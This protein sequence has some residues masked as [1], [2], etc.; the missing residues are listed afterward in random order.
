M[1]NNQVKVVKYYILLPSTEV[2]T[3]QFIFLEAAFK[4]PVIRA[5]LAPPFGS[6]NSQISSNHKLA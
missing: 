3:V 6:L 5:L 1:E 4:Q 2:S